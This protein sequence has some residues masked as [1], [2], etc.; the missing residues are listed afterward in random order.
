MVGNDTYGIFP[1]RGLRSAAFHLLSA[2]CYLLYFACRLLL[3]RFV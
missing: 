3:R 1:L 2:V